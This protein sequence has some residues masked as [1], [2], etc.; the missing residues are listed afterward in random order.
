MERQRA[1]TLVEHGQKSKLNRN[2]T[3]A[4][5][6]KQMHP[7]VHH[8]SYSSPGDL[9]LPRPEHVE[10]NCRPLGDIVQKGPAAQFYTA[11]SSRILHKS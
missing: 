8:V 11:L 9:F 10:K 1:L 2:A 6:V 4:R 3:T 5:A 7:S